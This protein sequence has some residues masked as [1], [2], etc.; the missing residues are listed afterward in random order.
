MNYL[1]NQFSIS[2]KH[3]V[4]DS[5]KLKCAATSDDLNRAFSTKLKIITY[6]FRVDG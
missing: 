5:G 4:D 1:I 3:F 2:F 6:E